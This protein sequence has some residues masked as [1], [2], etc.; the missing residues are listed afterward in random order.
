MALR[1]LTQVEIAAAR[2]REMA[3]NLILEA[4]ALEASV[5]IPSQ[6]KTQKKSYT[7]PLTGKAVKRKRIDL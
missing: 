3:K 1:E 2:L 4:E 5:S 6:K 7:N